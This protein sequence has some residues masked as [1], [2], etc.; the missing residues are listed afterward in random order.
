MKKILSLIIICFCYI[1]LFAQRL[2]DLDQHAYGF[3]NYHFNTIKASDKLNTK[4]LSFKIDSVDLIE[5]LKNREIIGLGMNTIPNDSLFSK[6]DFIFLTKQMNSLKD[7]KKLNEKYINKNLKKNLIYKAFNSKE[8]SQYPKETIFT[9]CAPLFSKDFS[10]VAI[11]IKS[12][13]G[14]ECA[15]NEINIYKKQKDNTW[16]FI[17]AILISIS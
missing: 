8:K 6:E 3:I 16:K 15:S 5:Y 13:C 9:I 1:N 7:L 10:I 11:N 17:G 2:N 12:F 14:I 4:L